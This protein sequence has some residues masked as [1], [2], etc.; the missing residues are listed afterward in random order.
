MTP[1]C[2]AEALA[3]FRRDQS[4]IEQLFAYGVAIKDWQDEVKATRS[5]LLPTLYQTGLVTT[6][7]R[8]F[9]KSVLLPLEVQGIL[10]PGQRVL[11]M[12]SGLGGIAMLFALAGY[13]VE[14]YDINWAS[15]CIARRVLDRLNDSLDSAPLDCNLHFGSYFPAENIA[16]RDCGR[17]MAEDLEDKYIR[18]FPGDDDYVFPILGSLTAR[19]YEDFDVFFNYAW[20]DQVASVCELFSLYAP[21]HGVL[22]MID[23]A[24]DGVLEEHYYDLF[25]IEQVAPFAY[26]K[27]S[28]SDDSVLSDD[29]IIIN[30][31]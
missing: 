2:P 14:G 26:Q 31:K 17:S 27:G 18:L 19:D 16:L 5:D 9:L 1:G 30:F 10:E 3:E 22:I 24:R 25:G 13:A 11:E 20:D 21:R 4:D 12:G 7:A 28:L 15:H 23:P 6:S 8:R 29:P